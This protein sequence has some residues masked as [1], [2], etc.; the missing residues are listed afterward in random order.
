MPRDIFWPYEATLSFTDSWQEQI[1]DG[2]G[3]AGCIGVRLD[4]LSYDE[5][6]LAAGTIQTAQFKVIPQLQN[7]LFGGQS[8]HTPYAEVL[9][10]P[11][12]APVL[13]GNA[14][15]LA[16]GILRPNEKFSLWFK[17]GT[18]GP[19]NILVRIRRYK[20]RDVAKWKDLL[21]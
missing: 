11:D 17:C 9:T 12:G 13:R 1:I 15:L 7:D 18:A 4:T 6:K 8:T 5:A 10:G 21:T 14:I 2:C 3:D 19:T 16:G 20:L